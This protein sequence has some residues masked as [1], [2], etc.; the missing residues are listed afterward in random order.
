METTL[1]VWF[2][3][4]A[5]MTLSGASIICRLRLQVSGLAGQFILRERQASTTTNA[6]SF[7][8]LFHTPAHSN[9]EHAMNCGRSSTGTHGKH[10]CSVCLKLECKHRLNIQV[11]TLIFTFISFLLQYWSLC[12]A[13]RYQ[14]SFWSTQ[15]L[16]KA[17]FVFKAYQS[18]HSVC[19][20]CAMY[21]RGFYLIWGKYN[22]QVAVAG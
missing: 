22:L 6:Q 12:F 8:W 4:L 19:Y 7:S 1:K 11:F 13:V 2:R 20:A 17:A 9:R 10:K 3:N 21:W 15:F 5:I 18:V 16:R 14:L